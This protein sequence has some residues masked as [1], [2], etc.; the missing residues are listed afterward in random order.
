M[1]QATPLNRSPS[2][3]FDVNSL[4]RDLR[5]KD[6]VL[7]QHALDLSNAALAENPA[8]LVTQLIARL[9]G[10]PSAKIKA[11]LRALHQ[12]PGNWLQPIDAPLL[13]A[14]AP[15]Q[16]ILNV[17]TAFDDSR[18]LVLGQDLKT[19]T[20]FSRH[21]FHVWDLESD[22]EIASMHLPM[23]YGQAAIANP[24]HTAVLTASQRKLLL[25]DLRAAKA[26]VIFAE[27]IMESLAI[28]ADA[29]RAVMTSVP[30]DWDYAEQEWNGPRTFRLFDLSTRTCIRTWQAHQ[31][32]VTDLALSHNGRFLATASR[33]RTSQLFDLDR[34]Q[35]I[36]SWRSADKLF[37]V[38]ITPTGHRFAYVSHGGALTVRRRNGKL[39]RRFSRVWA[40]Q[41]CLALS[42]NGNRIVAACDGDIQVLDLRQSKRVKLTTGTQPY[43]SSLATDPLARIAVSG[44]TGS[45]LLLWDLEKRQPADLPS[46]R[47]SV[48]GLWAGHSCVLEH[49]EGA[50]FIDVSTGKR[51]EILRPGYFEVAAAPSAGLWAIA[52]WSL[53]G[54]GQIRLGKWG[55]RGTSKFL[56]GPEYAPAFLCK[57][58]FSRDGRRL[59]IPIH[60]Q[61][62]RVVEVATGATIWENADLGLGVRPY[63]SPSG[64]YLALAS[65]TGHLQ[66]INLE[67]RAID[68]T[69]QLH[70]LTEKI[71]FL[72]D[73]CI[74]L[75]QN[76]ETI[77]LHWKTVSDKSLCKGSPSSLSDDG[78]WLLTESNSRKLTLW[79][80]PDQRK[81]AT[82]TLDAPIIET[83]LSPDGALLFASD[84]AGALHIL[85]NR[86]VGQEAPTSQ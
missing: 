42:A 5:G 48:S 75:S 15:I 71:L 74:V 83:A 25:V 43:L 21:S 85:Q 49:Q 14:G 24:P 64:S 52:K 20:A 76:L 61:G 65:L 77:F 84:Q 16:K 2:S 18:A 35:L 12:R 62:C 38:S 32:Y 45:Q 4:L 57:M 8:E 81:I 9:Q 51:H 41:S 36:G 11:L 30:T 23:D 44:E 33:D 58:H 56:S 53:N 55:R 39:L 66:I 46:V 60:R 67:T 50:A 17:G 73:D 1:T 22:R 59:A 34:F 3:T 40:N 79:K 27:D 72:D 10:Q 68:Q 26:E 29:S 31:A 13:P 28:S 37:A 69:L 7:V 78:N 80:L 54:G 6:K 47:E 82:Y 19:L 70:P 63:L 86:A